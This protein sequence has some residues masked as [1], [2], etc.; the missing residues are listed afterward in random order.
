MRVTLRLPDDWDLGS[1]SSIFG[2]H[3]VADRP[4]TVRVSFLDTFDWR[5][6]A[7]GGRLTDETTDD[8]RSLRW[9][10]ASG[11]PPY[12][13]PVSG[14]IQFANQLPESVLRS[15]LENL[16][17]VRALLPVGEV[18]VDRWIGRVRDPSGNTKVLLHLERAA[19]ADDSG[20]PSN[21][22]I[23]TVEVVGI[24]GSEQAFKDVVKR[25]RAIPGG[26]DCPDLMELAAAI[27]GRR[28][29]DYS[30]KLDLRL[31]RRQRADEALRTILLHLAST[32]R[33]NVDGVVADHD[34]EFLHDLR[35]ATR[36]TRA[37]LTQLKGVLPADSVA[38]YRDEFRWLGS[39]TGPCRDLD[40]N[41]LEMDTFRAMLGDSGE[42]LAPLQRALERARR[43]ALKNVRAGLRSA[44]FQRLTERWDAF[45][46][47]PS[48][49]DSVPPDADRP[50]GELASRKI[51]KAYRRLTKRGRG[52]GDTSP[53]EALHRLRIEAKKLRY[54]LEF[55]R[56]LYDEKEVGRL[57][58]G[59]KELQ[60]IL[61][62]I[63]DLHVQKERL[64]EF[65]HQLASEQE[66]ETVLAMG[67]LTAALE[68]RQNELR[69]QCSLAFDTFASP[70]NRARFS[71]LFEGT[72]SS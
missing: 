15:R 10:D 5:L 21:E 20:E 30:S 49:D 24:P 25:V 64:V 22:T 18:V 57:I 45:L 36:R 3:L 19:V 39:L 2:D 47:A 32:L 53:A 12:V 27:R 48:P 23:S 60:D 17:S 58:K 71:A 59:L 37:A 28:I 40:V 41:L 29:G 26:G 7:V 65:A 68:Q 67:R 69:Q 6:A 54:L 11:E 44:R 13:V 4:R 56:S 9:V 46:N 16:A 35:V 55:F 34:T 31:D 52:L 51:L 63:N 61:G 33:A 42:L 14:T 70:A 1:I 43:H 50:I 38:G 62:G 66:V 72:V 8:D